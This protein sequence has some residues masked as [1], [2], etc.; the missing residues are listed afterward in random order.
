MNS[1][2]SLAIF[3]SGNG[4]NAENICKFFASRNEIITRRIY[5]NRDDAFV[6]ERAKRLEVDHLVFSKSEFQQPRFLSE[7]ADIDYIVLAG[8]LL[9]IP[10]YLVKAFSGRIINI[11]PSLLPKF[12]G[13]GMFGDHVHKAVLANGEK[14]SGITV[15]EVN[16]NY[17]EGAIILQEKCV[18]KPT[19]SVETLAKRVHQL[20]YDFYPKTIESFIKGKML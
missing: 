14:E 1:P 6:L 13:K 11:H 8:F 17:D 18:V 19:D 20:E 12:G 7:L 9:L 16:E 3:A 10:N 15:H 4:T 2:A 5:C